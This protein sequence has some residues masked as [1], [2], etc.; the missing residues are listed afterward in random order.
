[1]SLLPYVPPNSI[2]N[3]EC[4]RNNCWHGLDGILCFS[5]WKQNCVKFG[6]FMCLG[7]KFYGNPGKMLFHRKITTKQ[8]KI[9]MWNSL[10]VLFMASCAYVVRTSNEFESRSFSS[11]GFQFFAWKKSLQLSI[12][13]N[14]IIIFSVLLDKMGFYVSRSILMASLWFPRKKYDILAFEFRITISLLCIWTFVNDAE[15]FHTSSLM[16]T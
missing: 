4:I 12:Y 9:R 8:T 5:E 15:C 7:A 6:R 3:S 10:M 2:L 16:L 11:I 14:L 13:E 1:M